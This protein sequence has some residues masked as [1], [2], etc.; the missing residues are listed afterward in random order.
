MNDR[1]RKML[2]LAKPQAMTKQAETQIDKVLDEAMIEAGKL[3]KQANIPEPPV[4]TPFVGQAVQPLL[5][6][7]IGN[8]LKGQYEYLAIAAYFK[9]VGLDGFSNYFMKQAGEEATHAAKIID[10]LMESGTDFRMPAVAAPE[11]VYTTARHVAERYLTLEKG[12][13]QNWLD[14]FRA[15]DK[16][17]DYAVIKLAQWFVDEQIQ[18]EDA[19]V[20]FFQ[21]VAIAGEGAGLL[22]LDQEYAK[23]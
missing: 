10:Y 3:E 2:E 6:A 17:D 20:T 16:T 18:E 12:I 23:R 1:L 5:T 14:I 21:K 8:E 9:K 4:Q 19:A 11:A 22:I 15:A 13:T 7:Q